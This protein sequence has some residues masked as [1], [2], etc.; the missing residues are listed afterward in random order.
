MAGDYTWDQMPEELAERLYSLANRL[1][2][3]S[4]EEEAYG[5]QE[6]LLN[7]MKHCAATKEQWPRMVSFCS[8]LPMPGSEFCEK[9]IPKEDI[10]GD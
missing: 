6:W 7:E 3:A 5:L 1:T 4:I 2:P 9:H 8:D 10:D